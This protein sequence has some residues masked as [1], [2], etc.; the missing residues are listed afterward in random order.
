MR[1][2]PLTI[3]LSDETLVYISVGLFHGHLPET[4]NSWE[5]VVSWEALPGPEAG[6]ELVSCSYRMK[7]TS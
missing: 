7:V 1:T 2:E 5:S 6:G 4:K 3:F